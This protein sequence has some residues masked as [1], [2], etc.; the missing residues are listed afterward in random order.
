MCSGGA[1]GL[2]GGFASAS[3]QEQSTATQTREIIDKININKVKKEEALTQ[4]Q[5][6]QENQINQT[7]KVLG[8]QQAQMGASGLDVSSGTFQK[9]STDTAKTGAID[10]QTIQRNALMQAWG[11][12]AENTALFNKVKGLEKAQ[13]YKTLTTMLGGMGGLF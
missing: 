13:E 8:A 10:S 2:F 9:L 7:Q 5:I 6:A 12:D 4:G 11:Y 3:G 1:L